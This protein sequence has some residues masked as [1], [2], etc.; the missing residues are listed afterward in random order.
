[1]IENTYIEKKSLAGFTKKNVDWD[2]IAKDC[3]CLSNAFGGHI[4]IGIEDNA[5]LPPENQLIPLELP[6][7]IIKQI[8]N[9][10]I[11]VSLQSMVITAN[12]NSEF[13]DISVSRNNSSISSTTNGKYYI[14]V[15]DECKPILP[16]EMLRLL[17]DR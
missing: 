11:G 13:I 16:D 6:A 15:E 4:Y 1:M 14:R 8:L 12:N 5:D 9:R 7:K 17:N 3:V 10:T 2:E